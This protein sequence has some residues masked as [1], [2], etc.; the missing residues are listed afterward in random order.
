M[1]HEQYLFDFIKSNK[2]LIRNTEWNKFFEN[3]FDFIYK[4]YS[5]YGNDKGV[6]KQLLLLMDKS[7]YANFEVDTLSPRLNALTKELD[8]IFDF[9][10]KRKT[11]S[12]TLYIEFYEITEQI[13]VQFGFSEK[14]IMD[15]ITG[16]DFINF[17]C[18]KYDLSVDRKRQIFYLKSR[19]TI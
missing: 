6:Y 8:E 4:N 3:W 5:I 19:F 7:G 2:E 12:L 14:E 17:I 9:V 16:S 15:I 11:S 13:C 18:K 10:V 1:I